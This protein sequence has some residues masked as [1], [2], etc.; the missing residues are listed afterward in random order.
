MIDMAH[1]LDNVRPRHAL[2]ASCG[3]QFGGIAIKDG[4]ITCPECGDVFR[5]DLHGRG[6]ELARLKEKVKRRRVAAWLLLAVA[7]VI[8]AATLK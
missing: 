8:V 7:L 1:P 2:C 5:F 4:V 3:Y 6:E